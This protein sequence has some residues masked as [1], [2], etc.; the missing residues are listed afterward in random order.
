MLVYAYAARIP[1]VG[2]H[3]ARDGGRL[4]HALRRACRRAFPEMGLLRKWVVFGVL[5]QMTTWIAIAVLLGGVFGSIAGAVASRRPAAGEASRGL[6]DGYPQLIPT[7]APETVHLE[8]D[9]DDRARLL[10]TPSRW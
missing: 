1:V 10:E 9:W 4:G 3:A 2:H 7:Q 8:R 6:T 5:P